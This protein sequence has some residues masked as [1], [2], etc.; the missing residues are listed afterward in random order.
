M[1]IAVVAG[2]FLV[3][4]PAWSLVHLKRH[5][6]FDGRQRHEH[7]IQQKQAEYVESRRRRR[8]GCG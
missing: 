2:C 8:C 3:Y 7:F 1:I 4:M 5:I 6:V